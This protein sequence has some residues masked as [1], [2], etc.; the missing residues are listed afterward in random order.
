MYLEVQGA[1]PEEL[2]GLSSARVELFE[3]MIGNTDFSIVNFH[4][5]E[6][7]RMPDATYHPIPYDFD[8]SGFVDAPY[9][10]PSVVLPLRSVRERLYRGYC[11]PEVDMTSLFESF[12]S[13]REAAAGLI[14]GQPELAPKRAERAVRYLEEF[15][16]TIDTPRARRSRIERACRTDID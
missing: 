14:H 2:D 7:V 11:H 16:E 12:L 9:A 5:M 4:N 10:S 6:L 13:R 8:F 15:F 1:K 3:Y